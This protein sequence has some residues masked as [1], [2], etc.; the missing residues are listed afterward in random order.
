MAKY[1][2]NSNAGKQTRPSA[3]MRPGKS[4]VAATNP[5]SFRWSLPALAATAAFP[6][7]ITASVLHARASKVHN[8]YLFLIQIP[9][10][11]M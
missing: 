11:G 10:N 8:V 2:F 3:Q 5:E 6:T 4:G 7:R 1:V 9:G